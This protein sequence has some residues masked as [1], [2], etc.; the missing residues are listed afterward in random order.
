M[1]NYSVPREQQRLG[2]LDRSS[3]LG[4]N[5]AD[6]KCL[7]ENAHDALQ[8]HGEYR[9]GTFVGDE[10]ITVA[11]QIFRTQNISISFLNIN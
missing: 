1:A 4:E 11:W 2:A 6:H 8:A 10:S 9:F 7:N 5:D 3:Q